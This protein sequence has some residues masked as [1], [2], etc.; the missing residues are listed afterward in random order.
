MDGSYSGDKKLDFLGWVNLF[1]DN[2][3]AVALK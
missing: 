2:F 1:G 3:L